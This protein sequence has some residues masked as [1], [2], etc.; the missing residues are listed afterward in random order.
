[1]YGDMKDMDYEE[2]EEVE[3]CKEWKKKAYA[4][5][6]SPPIAFS[7]VFAPTDISNNCLEQWSKSP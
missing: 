2:M 5:I 1:M 4:H 6:D 7:C 3:E